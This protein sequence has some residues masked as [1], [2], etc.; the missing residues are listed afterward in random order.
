M[1]KN[2]KGALG[3]VALVVIGVACFGYFTEPVWA[4]RAAI[5]QDLNNPDKQE[6]YT[7]DFF[8]ISIPDGTAGSDFDAPPVPTGKHLIIEH[9][10]GFWFVPNNQIVL[11]YLYVKKTPTGI[12][13]GLI[14]L[15]PIPLGSGPSYSQ[16]IVN[17]QTWFR[18]AEGEILGVHIDRTGGNGVASAQFH[19]KGYLISYP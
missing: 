17:Q 19:V 10:S 4:Q 7:F 18:L 13:G 11:A 14:F 2:C 9:V 6:I 12:P 15:V 8:P 5:I 3:M 16:S 1:F